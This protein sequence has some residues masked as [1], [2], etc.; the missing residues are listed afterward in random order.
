[1]T[2][3]TKGMLLGFCGVIAFS[4]TLPLTRS[5]VPFFD[6]VFIATARVVVAAIVAGLWLLLTKQA[7]PSVAQFSQLVIVA[8]GVVFGFPIFSSIAMKSLPASH[9]GVVLGLLP[10][11][12]ALVAAVIY[13]ERPSVG[14]WIVSLI[15]STLVIAY[16]LFKGG[17]HFQSGD[18]ALLIAAISI[19]IS[20]ASG[21]NLS[22]ELGGL[23]VVSWA[24]VISAP[25]SLIIALMTMPSDVSLVSP[26]DWM[27]FLYLA[28]VSQWLSFLFW[29]KG[30]V[31]GGIAR[32]SQTQLLQPFI[33]IMF[34]IVLLGER[35]D[36]T[37]LL[38]AG[39]VALVVVIGR[40]FRAA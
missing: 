19:S 32:V 26:W 39:L 29:N 13:K 28:L 16:S 38:F 2:N 10:I 33:T 18:F 3:E 1:M 23:Q 6:P 21:A 22:R 34:S 25:I 37:T 11:V 9:G 14:F 40:K 30:L 7:R 36:F 24:I 35:L 17:G 5:L 31:L 15:G 4:L 8:S 20:Y 27:S 12:T